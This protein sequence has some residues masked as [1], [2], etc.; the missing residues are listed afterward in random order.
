VA[1][2]TAL[3][4]A[5]RA[6]IA[7]ELDG[8]PWRTLPDT[9]VLACGLDVGVE[10]DRRRV[11]RLRTELRRTE[12]RAVAGKLLRY[13]DLAAERLETELA[14]RGVAPADRRETVGA[15]RRVGILDDARLAMS[16]AHALA[17]RGYGDAAIRWRLTAEGISEALAEEALSGLEPERV[18]AK[19]VV[20]REGASPRTARLL[21]RRGF[22]EEAVE[23][24]IPAVAD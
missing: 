1:R 21:A 2:V 23:A 6:S 7:V 8:A 19:N 15:L 18:R 5:G 20:A 3:R 9:A 11:R 12:A 13:R 22:A 17:E 24:A 14:R 10:L 4:K 16:R